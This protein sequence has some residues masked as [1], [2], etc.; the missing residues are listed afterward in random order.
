MLIV[1]TTSD[2][3]FHGV[4]FSFTPKQYWNI[5]RNYTI[6]H[7][8]FA[9]DFFFLWRC[10]PTRV[11]ASS[12]L[13]FLDHTQRRTTVGR[14]LLDE[15]FARRRDLY[16]TTHN[17]HNKQISMP[18]GGFEL[19]ISASELPQ[20]YALDRAVTGIGYLILFKFQNHTIIGHYLTRAVKYFVT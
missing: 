11:M 1:V 14:T 18:P 5:I 6:R 17:T 3:D 12:F 9:L 13:R 19:T 20:T 7:V 16:M 10:D 15:W 8:P 4:F 2:R